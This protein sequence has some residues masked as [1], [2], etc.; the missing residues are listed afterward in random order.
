M[1][2]PKKTNTSSGAADAAASSKYRW[3]MMPIINEAAEFPAALW[4]KM[5]END[6]NEN[7]HDMR[8]KMRAHMAI[9]EGPKRDTITVLTEVYAGLSFTD[10]MAQVIERHCKA[11]RQAQGDGMWIKAQHPDKHSKMTVPYLYVEVEGGDSRIP[12]TPQQSDI[13]ARDWAVVPL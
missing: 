13:F 1:R 7:D 12:W 4:E 2:T 10:A 6:S 11:T 3:P 5:V 8:Q 9:G